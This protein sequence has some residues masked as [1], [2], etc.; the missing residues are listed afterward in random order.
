MT[1]TLLIGRIVSAYF[2]VCGLGFLVSPDFYQRVAR[3]A[4]SS[5]PLTINL[6]GMVHFLIGMTILVSHFQFQSVLEV[7]VTLIGI[8]FACKGIAFIVFPKA[9]LKAAP[10]S[11]KALRISGIAFVLVGL[12]VGYLSYLA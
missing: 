6:S 7:L 3:N 4:E 1:I 8:A 11:T 10:V 5:D 12:I 9:T 2:L